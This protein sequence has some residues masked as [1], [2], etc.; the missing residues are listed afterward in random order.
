MSSPKSYLQTHEGPRV[1]VKV[2]VE[3]HGPVPEGFVVDHR[4]GDIHDNRLENLRLA[5]VAQNIANSKLSVVNS[6]G[7]KG[8]SWDSA[9]MKFRGAIKLNYKQH[10]VRGDLL[11][12]AAWLFRNR[13]VLHGEFA[14]H[15]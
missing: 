1:H 10:A 5:T 4:N 15:R 8:L 11:E 2:W 12:V 9:R 14:R 6:T 7:L 13:E 3:A